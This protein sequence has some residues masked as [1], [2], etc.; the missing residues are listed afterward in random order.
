MRIGVVSDVHGNEHALAA[1][2]TRL[3]HERIDH[4]VM[5]GDLLSYGCRPLEVLE[6]VHAA[7]RRWPTEFLVGNHDQLYFELQRGVEGYVAQVHGWIQE[8]ARWTAARLGSTRLEVMFPWR[9]QWRTGDVLFAHA[10]PFAPRDWTYLNGEG[11][12]QRAATALEVLGCRVGV[13]G[14]T[15]RSF[16]LRLGG[17]RLVNPGSLGQP[18]DAVGVSTVALL[19]GDDWRILEVAYDE[20]AHRADVE[21]SGLSTATQR[22]ILKFH[23]AG[24]A[25]GGTR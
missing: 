15:H 24:A 8:S 11:E 1:A 22:E 9:E 17:V 13:F 25:V 18:R 3:E 10:N 19:D 12:R 14:H 4:L 6:R 2:L 7:S 23:G 5:L 21:Q 20:A 16:D